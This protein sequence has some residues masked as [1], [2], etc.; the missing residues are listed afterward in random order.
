METNNT[1]NISD[2]Q[3]ILIMIPLLLGGFIALLNETLL[4]VAFPQLV[5]SL[6]VPTNT[7]QWLGTAYM[8]VIGVLVPVVAFLLKTYPTRTLY[9]TAMV[10]FTVGTILCGISWAF[11]V[12]LISQIIQGVGTGMLLPIMTNSI[13]DIYPIEKRGSALGIS[14]MIVVVAPGVGPALSGIVLQYLDWHWLFFLILPFAIIAIVLGFLALKNVSILTKP[15]ID[16]LSVLLSSIGFG[17]LIFGICSIEM[18]GFLNTTVLISLFCGVSGLTLFSFRQFS[19]KQ[20][21]LELRTFRSPQFSLGI[22]MLFITFMMPFAVNIILPTFMQSG[23]GIVPMVAGFA[24]LPGS[25]V[26][27]V[28]APVSGYLYDK[29]GAK[30]LA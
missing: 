14:M 5:S 13:L 18:K 24:L 8:L 3:R 23:L 15:K 2:K 11:P 21:M 1:K 30:P 12:L 17:G 6:H 10:F 9:L 4:N 28:V 27:G 22:I 20:P 26:N 16:I 7:V 19:L 29:L 25:I